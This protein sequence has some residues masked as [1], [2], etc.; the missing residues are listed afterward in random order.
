MTPIK[1]FRINDLQ[2]WTEDYAGHREL[3]CLSATK[4]HLHFVLYSLTN[5]HTVKTLNFYN[6]EP[7]V[8]EQE[9]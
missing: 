6:D 7:Y 4:A 1:C 3:I 2:I 9:V 8:E 5:F